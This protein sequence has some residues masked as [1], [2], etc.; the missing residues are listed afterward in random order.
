LTAS[1]GNLD[2]VMEIN[3]NDLTQ[4]LNKVEGLIESAPSKERVFQDISRQQ[5]VKQQLYLFLLQKK[6]ETAIMKSGTSSASRLIE[7][8][9]SEPGPF[10]PNRQ[11]IYLIGLLVGLF[12]PAAG[13]YMSEL[14]N[15]K[16][17][18]KQ[19]IESRTDIPIVGE[20]GINRST[21]T[22][23]VERESRSAIA[24]QFRAVRTNLQFLLAGKP[25]KIILI[26][27]SM[28]GEGKSFISANL[29]STLAISGKKVA[30]LELDLRKPKLSAALNLPNDNGFTNYI[31]SNLELKYLPKPVPDNPNLFVIGS[32][33][34]P[35]NPAELLLHDKVKTMFEY[36]NDNFDY[37]VIDSPPVGLVTDALLISKYTDVTL[38]IL[39]PRYTFRQQLEIVEELS[40]NRKMHG[41]SILLNQ[42]KANSGRRYGYGYGY[43]YGYYEYYSGEKRSWNLMRLFRKSD[44]K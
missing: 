28:S 33:P 8:A 16:I 7:P 19:D 6:E 10:S 42:V 32:G 37:I 39:R 1:L 3:K 38:F 34:I 43:G 29:A 35:P 25:S 9:R 41:I 26:T 20:I 17:R 23:V 30:L 36:L 2:K 5:V 4:R 14:L 27:S 44:S 13:I 21:K 12:I 15:D 40:K 11:N 18:D 31:V 24:E 22:L